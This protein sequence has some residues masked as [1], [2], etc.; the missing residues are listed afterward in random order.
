MKHRGILNNQL[1]QLLS[2]AG[3]GDLI[4]ITDRGFPLPHV[5]HTQVIDLGIAEG[6]PAF[7][8]IAALITAEVVVEKIY[9]TSE[10]RQANPAMLEFVRGLMPSDLPYHEIPHARLKQAVLTGGDQELG[11]IIGFVRTGEFTGYTNILLQCG[12]AF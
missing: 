9:V 12:V 1:L 6:L 7:N 5:S 2:S 4:V 3:H 8:E 10:T 11:R